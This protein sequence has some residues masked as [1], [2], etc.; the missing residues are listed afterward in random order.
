MAHR[1]TAQ[2]LE[3]LSASAAAVRITAQSYEVL[4][5][6]TAAVRPTAQSL[7]VLSN[8]WQVRLPK[9]YAL[10]VLGIGPGP[11]VQKS[12]ALAVLDD[13]SLATYDPYWANVV[14]LCHFDGSN[15]AT[16]TVDSSPSAKTL[17]VN[18][19]AQLSTAQSKFGG[20]AL[21]L[22]GTGDY[23][24]AADS[25]DW[26]FGTAPFTVELFARFAVV[27]TQIGFVGQYESGGA[28]LTSSWLFSR[29][30]SLEFRMVNSGGSALTITAAWTPVTGT[31]YHLAVDRDAGGAV[32]I[33]VDG[34]VM[35]TSASALAGDIRDVATTP[36]RVGRSTG[37]ANTDLN[38]YM[39]EV[40]VT[41]GVCRYGGQFTVPQI[42]YPD[43]NLITGTG[44]NTLA[45]LTSTAAGAHGVDGAA[46][47]TLASVTSTASGDFTNGTE[48]TATNTLSALVSAGTG[49]AIPPEV[50]GTGA[51]T[52]ASVTSASQGTF[53]TT[54]TASNTLGALTSAGSG[55]LAYTG[56]AANVLGALTSTGAAIHLA[57][58]TG[59]SSLT[60]EALASTGAGIHLQPVLGV[61]E[62]TLDSLISNGTGTVTWPPPRVRQVR[63]MASQ[64]TVALSATVIGYARAA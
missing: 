11:A 17:T 39:E 38:G 52:L 20:S 57:P 15:G 24:S 23:I 42:A 26:S 22:D 64:R 19:N 1:V 3:V 32:R 40:R 37:V 10:A 51:D 28:A 25:T 6:S 29:N 49:T 18:G 60:L 5:S 7:E 61:G 16:S 36:L 35:A 33:Y 43:Y 30:T 44:A 50:T 53:T 45:S 58:V 4:A 12:Y 21:L 46:S 62:T 27:G 41:K 54:G 14:L 48:G 55:L 63:L 8:T 2:S 31:W 59:T 47:N 9:A 13:G 34:A 56:T